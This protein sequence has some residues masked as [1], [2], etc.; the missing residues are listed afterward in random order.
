M[1]GRYSVLDGRAAAQG[2]IKS[3]QEPPLNTE[4]VT[5]IL[6]I[7]STRA[8]LCKPSIKSVPRSQSPKAGKRAPCRHV[9]YFQEAITFEVSE[10]KAITVNQL[11]CVSGFGLHYFEREWIRKISIFSEFSWYAETGAWSCEKTESAYELP[12][13]A[14]QRLG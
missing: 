10:S 11:T 8:G 14:Q 3:E 5:F 2:R 7:L 9:N 1:Q 4:V 12:Q 13:Y 6:N